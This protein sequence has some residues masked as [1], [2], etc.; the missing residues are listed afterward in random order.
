[1]F[2]TKTALKAVFVI[3]I[4][5][6]MSEPQFIIIMG[7]KARYEKVKKLSGQQ[8]AYLAGIVDGE[9]TITLTRHNVYRN[10]YLTL[11]I[12]NCE[13]PLLT[14]VAGLIGV[15]QITTKRVYNPKH[16]PGYTYQV[17]SRQAMDL[18]KMI[19]PHLRTYKKK[20]AE[21]AL[22]HYLKLTPRNGKYT[23]IMLNQRENFIEKF[24]AILPENAK[25]RRGGSL[26][27]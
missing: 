2:I 1:M 6:L 8:A 4:S 11:T 15:G 21:F 3:P 26:R 13:L 14:Y 24:F 23:P 25:T 9:G 27:R 19:L 7:M 17:I 22:K 10:R 20:R 5:R 18:I 12:S 16:S